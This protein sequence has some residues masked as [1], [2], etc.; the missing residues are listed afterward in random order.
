MK[1]EKTTEQDV[2]NDDQL[3]EKLAEVEVMVFD[4]IKAQVA[5]LIEGYDKLV[6]NNAFDKDGMT[7]IDTARKDLVKRRTG[8][9]GVRKGL[10]DSA[11]KYQKGINNYWR[12]IETDLRSAE[13]RL[14][15]KFDFWAKEKERLEKE[16][17][18]GRVKRLLVFNMVQTATAYIFRTDKVNYD[19]TIDD[20]KNSEDSYFEQF[21][22]EV[23][24][25]YNKDQSEKKAEADR[26]EALRLENVRKA[27]ELEDREKALAAKEAKMAPPKPPKAPS[28][29]LVDYNEAVKDIPTRTETRP[30]FATGGRITGEPAGGEWIAPVSSR[31][32]PIMEREFV[33]RNAQKMGLSGPGWKILQVDKGTGTNIIDFAN[34]TK[35]ED[36]RIIF[37]PNINEFELDDLIKIASAL[38]ANRSNL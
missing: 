36:G 3:K 29:G 14:Q 30:S 19:I 2:V 32:A 37:Q 13:K 6:I 8:G 31:Q 7:A 10:V 4:P 35:R 34:V 24:F 33:L 11:L 18:D 25:E 23:E 28:P 26:L 9:D 15:D 21:I 38:H 5:A 20:V 22:K 17:Y 27:K 16:K 1:K 12:P